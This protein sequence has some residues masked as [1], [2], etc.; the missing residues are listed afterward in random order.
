MAL[1]GCGAFCKCILIFFNVIFALVGFACLGL[2]LWLRFSDNTR[3]IF[4]I[5]DFD[6]STF[7]VGVTLLIV[8][9][10]VMLFVVM[11][12]GYVACSEERCAL[13]VFTALLAILALAEVVVGVLVYTKRYEVG[14]R[15]AEFYSSLYLLY[16]KGE[17]DPA[18]GVA[19]M[20]IHNTLHCCGLTGVPIIEVAQHTCPD[21]GSFSEMFIMPTCPGVISEVFDSRAP[22]VMGLFLGTA[23]LLII[24]LICS[25]TLSKKIQLSVS[26]P[27]YIILT[28]STPVLANP[29]PSQQ[30]FVSTSYPYPDQDPV[31]FTP[32]SAVNLPVAQP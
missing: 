17:G 29:Q 6:S 5:H 2:G 7:V 32:L 31:I 15:A 28:H 16:I 19:L 24:A 18:I 27:Q 3:V 25:I 26:S 9:G 1:D 20:F 21:P 14:S 8:L 11:V 30:Q 13:I 22:L 23:A 4:T 12:G 10:C